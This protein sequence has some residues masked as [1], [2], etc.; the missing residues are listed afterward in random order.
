MT[1]KVQ[2]GPPQIAIHQGQ[3]VLITGEDGADQLAERQ[4]PLFPRYAGR[5]QLED[6][7]QCQAPNSYS[8]SRCR[9]S[10]MSCRPA[11]GVRCKFTA[12][13]SRPTYL[14]RQALRRLIDAFAASEIHSAAPNATV[15]LASA[16]G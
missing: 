5:Q 13:P 16:A 6:L 9:V 1:V 10:S 2:V 3:T 4:G 14:Q 7:R 15:Q 11:L 12:T 8:R